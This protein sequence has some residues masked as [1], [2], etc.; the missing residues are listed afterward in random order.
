[1]KRDTLLTMSPE[2]HKALAIKWALIGF[3]AS[4]IGFNGENYD[5]EKYPA[6]EGLLISYFD[7]IYR[8]EQGEDFDEGNPTTVARSPTRRNQGAE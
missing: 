2:A 5:R 1:M 8:R 7:G 4:G 6:V 3:A